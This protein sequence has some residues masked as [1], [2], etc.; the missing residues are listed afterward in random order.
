MDEVLALRSS[1]ELHNDAYTEFA[2]LNRCLITRNREINV[3]P[4]ATCHPFRY[5]AGFN[6]RDKVRVVSHLVLQSLQ[7]GE[8]CGISR[9]QTLLILQ[10]RQLKP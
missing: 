2:P 1:F 4:Q 6:S 7:E 5:F 3:I 8:I 9:P 10:D